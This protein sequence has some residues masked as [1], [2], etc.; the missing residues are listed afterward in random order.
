V[1]GLTF[2]RIFGT[3]VRAH[4]TWV[5][6]TAFIAVIFGMDLTDGT[7]A[8]WP[9]A[10]AWGSSITVALLIFASVTAHELAHVKIARRNG[11]LV[12]RVT[13]Q[14]LGGPYVMEV[15]PKNAG[16][17]IRIALA[18]PAFS[19]VIALTFGIVGAIL[20]LGPLETAPDGIQAIA[21]VTTMVA[22]FNMLLGL[23]NLV[24]GYPM[25][26]ARILHALVWRATGSESVA[27]SAAIRVGRNVGVALIAIGLVTMTFADLVAGMTLVIAGW[28][29]MS[30]S[31]FLD[32]RTGLQE[33][34]AGLHVRDA[35]DTDLAHVPPQLT[36]DVFAA[37]YLGERIG[38]AALVE[39]NDELVGLIGTAQVK[40]IPRGAW[41]KTRTEDAM[42]P[43]ARVPWVPADMDLWAALELLERTGLD[44]LL[45]MPDV[46]AGGGAANPA[47]S[48]TA[49]SPEPAP[50]AEPAFTGD[51]SIVAGTAGPDGGD[52]DKPTTTLLTRRS[53]AKLVHEKAEQ[54]HR[55]I[56]AIAAI[57]KGRFRGR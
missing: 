53:A 3:E 13:I 15:R 36:I 52:V 22:A 57:R 10:L 26:G 16:E 51:A 47:A 12:P 43:I 29:V 17:E 32:R 19:L 48:A 38:G 41:T 25:D 37:A 45:V 1:I 23:I 5:P 27:T 14:L 9:T 4:W 6:I 18:G 33:L 2:G 24:P 55:Q 30:S 44:G 49:D 42:I 40:R 20:V 7:A 46:A 50:E 31:R 34:I 35:G 21:F 56:L 39:H 28:L 8:N 54:K 11:Q